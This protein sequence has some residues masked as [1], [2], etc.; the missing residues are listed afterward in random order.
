MY[1]RLDSEDFE[2]MCIKVNK[3]VVKKKQIL[4]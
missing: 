2:W 1:E 4:K 3:D